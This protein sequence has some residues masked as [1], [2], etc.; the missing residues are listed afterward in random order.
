MGIFSKV[1][2]AQNQLFTVPIDL[3]RPSEQDARAAAQALAIIAGYF[4]TK[5]LAAVAKALSNPAV[6]MMIKSKL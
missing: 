5:E 2:T 1:L 3:E 6:R 4:E